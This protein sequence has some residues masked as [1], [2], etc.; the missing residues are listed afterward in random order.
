MSLR[1]SRKK[2]ERMKITPV[3]FVP[4]AGSWSRASGIYQSFRLLERLVGS[5]LVEARGVKKGRIYT[6]LRR[7]QAEGKLTVVGRGRGAYYT[8]AG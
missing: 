8:A 3:N 1:K 5:G 6:L 4:E 7:L 2:K